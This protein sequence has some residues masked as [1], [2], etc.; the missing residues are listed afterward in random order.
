[1]RD[2]PPPWDAPRDAISYIEA[3]GLTQQP[4]NATANQRIFTLRV[5]VDGGPVTVP[6]YLGVDRLRAVQA[7]IHTH[8]ESGQ[9][10]LEGDEVYSATLS[11]LF[12]LWGVRF[13]DECL[14]SACGGITVT[15]DGAP[16]ADPGGLLLADVG[17]VLEVSA[18]SR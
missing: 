7:V 5:T 11:Q 6:A 18:V 3:A 15:A 1:M 14:G 12:T 10:W 8:D 2:T 13:D 17:D 4:L 9:V 16:V